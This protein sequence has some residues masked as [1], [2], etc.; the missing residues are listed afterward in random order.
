MPIGA[1]VGSHFAMRKGASIIK[2]LLVLTSMALA[3]RL[4]ADPAHPLRAWL[5]I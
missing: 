5:G 1:Q 4:L 3:I 2:P